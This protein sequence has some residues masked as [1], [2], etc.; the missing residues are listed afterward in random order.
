MDK[1]LFASTFCTHLKVHHLQDEVY[2]TPQPTPL[3]TASR[4][5]TGRSRERRLR[6]S[7]SCSSLYAS[8]RKGQHASSA[9]ED[10]YRSTNSSPRKSS[11]RMARA[12]ESLRSHSMTNGVN[13]YS[14][15]AT[16]TLESDTDTP[17]EKA[18]T[19]DPT[20]K[21]EPRYEA[22]ET[23]KKS[24]QKNGNP[25]LRL[26]I[27]RSAK[28]R[29]TSVTFKEEQAKNGAAKYK[30]A[31]SEL[32]LSDDEAEQDE[33]LSLETFN[34]QDSNLKPAPAA[35]LEEASRDS[36]NCTDIVPLFPATS[37]KTSMTD[38]VPVEKVES[39][40]LTSFASGLLS[41]KTTSIKLPLTG[42]GGGIGVGGVG[43]G[44]GA[45]SPYSFSS[46]RPAN[47][48]AV[49]PVAGQSMQAG[50]SQQGVLKLNVAIAGEFSMGNFSPG[51]NQ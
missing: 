51:P 11:D 40:S 18:H 46:P 29:K 20:F 45:R 16:D 9:E 33:V 31:D 32:D 44:G 36:N 38:L 3:R 25:M 37:K 23:P 1:K 30:A 5:V 43:G 13:G 26:A 41:N 4:P 42:P 22:P 49:K 47:T 14:A 27:P 24:P 21:N 7:N 15:P 8:P 19:P 50:G 17:E 2:G 34:G 12:A 48:T 10:P 28:G 6:G 39:R 35:P